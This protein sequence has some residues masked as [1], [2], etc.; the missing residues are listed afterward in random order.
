MYIFTESV[1]TAKHTATDQT[2][3]SQVNGGAT[4]E[5]LHD[6]PGISTAEAQY[7]RLDHT[8]PERQS[9]PTGRHPSASDISSPRHNYINVL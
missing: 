4:Y 5:E 2:E 3:P 8:T 6:N 7:S 1:T 9:A